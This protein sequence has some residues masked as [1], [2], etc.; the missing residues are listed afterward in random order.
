M[1]RKYKL[2][3][4]IT[5]AAIFLLLSVIISN[6]YIE[7]N[8][9]SYVDDISD[10]ARIVLITD[11]HGKEY[12]RDNEKLIKKIS[13]INPDIIC[14]A[15]D[16]IDESNTKEDIDK[17]IDLLEKLSRINQTYYSY[18]NHDTAYFNI[19]G[20]DALK[21]IE[22]TGCIILNEEYVDIDINYKKIRLGGMY[23]YAFNQQYLPSEEWMSDSTFVFLK[24]FISTDRT[25]ILMCHR[26][27]SF[28][29]E[30][31]ALWN[32]DYVLCGHTHGGIWRLPFIGG[33]IAPEQ[34]FFPEYDKGEFNIGNIK[35]I[36]SSG[37][38]GYKKF[39]RLFNSPEITVIEF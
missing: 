5:A 28:I 12:G 22:S 30:D 35:M 2:L 25:T 37:L 24:D 33:L 11:L 20:Y 32:I 31:A 15:G 3:F 18:G 6:Y 7:I 38:S 27:E 4:S 13:E 9:Y 29:Y 23:D 34:G 21:E 8:T 14:L 19:A 17:F 16:F 39:P 36:I 1:S 10:A 26:P